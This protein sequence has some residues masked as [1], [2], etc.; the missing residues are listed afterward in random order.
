MAK[1]TGVSTPTIRY[2]EEIGL[3]PPA[4]RTTSGQRSYDQDDLGSLTFI[5]Q[6][7]DF[8]FWNRSGTGA[9]RPL[10]QCRS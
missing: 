6:C 9:P 7:R 3:L 10:D 1:A 4:N 5:K 2:Y 8:G